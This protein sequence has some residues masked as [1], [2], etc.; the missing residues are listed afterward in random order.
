MVS[1]GAALT[2]ER[3]HICGLS[4]SSTSPIFKST[5]SVAVATFPVGVEVGTAGHDRSLARLALVS[6]EHG[7]I[8]SHELLHVV[9]IGTRDAIG[10]IHLRQF[11]LPR[12]QPPEHQALLFLAKI[13]FEPSV[14]GS[15]LVTERC[16]TC[17]VAETVQDIRISHR[18]GHVPFEL[19][20]LS[21]HF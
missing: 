1:S 11:Q 3:G 8:I 13:G 14:D 16:W 20:N 12:V 15:L 17:K 4:S 2:R 21:H 6:V 5:A 10:L 18:S 7:I 9:R 19:P